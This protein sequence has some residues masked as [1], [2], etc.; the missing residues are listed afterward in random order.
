MKLDVIISTM[1]DNVFPLLKKLTKVENVTYIIIRQLN[2]SKYTK[3]TE[4]QNNQ[5]VHLNAV[6]YEY[7][8][9]GLTRSRNRGIQH[10]FSD[11][12]LFSDDDISFI[13]GF[14]EIIIDSF[15]TKQDADIITFQIQTPEGISF[16]SY[17][18]KE[19]KHSLKTIGKVSSIEIACKRDSLIKKRL[20]FDE[21]FGL[22]A[23]YELGE[24]AIFLADAIRSNM[25]AYYIPQAIIIHEI[26]SSG[27]IYN[28]KKIMAR[29]AQFERIF[30]WKAIV[31]GLFFALKKYREYRTTITFKQYYY[32]FLKGLFDFNT[33][34]WIKQ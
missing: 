7:K 17:N 1:N 31:I 23:N 8:E 5:L 13:D 14:Q 4:D 34:K 2:S 18:Q 28:K 3:I 29:G 26:E 30:G 21:F 15:E 19:Y 25:N 6:V 11:I 33:I 32:W 9:T 12:L 16:K 20:L 24:E 27:K 10:S 22:G